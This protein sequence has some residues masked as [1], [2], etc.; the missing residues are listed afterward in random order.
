MT[1]R[2]IGSST[3]SRPAGPAV[4]RGTATPAEGSTTTPSRPTSD[5]VQISDAGRSANGAGPA[6]AAG[7]LTPERVEGLRK[8]VLDGAYHSLS[9]VEQVAQRILASGDL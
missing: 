7:G 2:H 8:K 5:S 3:P 6:R 4:S 9:A 1:I